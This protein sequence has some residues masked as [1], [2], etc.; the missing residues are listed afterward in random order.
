MNRAFSIVAFVL[1][2]RCFPTEGRAVWH[3]ALLCARQALPGMSAPEPIS[4][5]RTLAG[6]VAATCKVLLGAT[7]CR[8]PSPLE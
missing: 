3:F 8:S 7:P 6:R 5:P 2:G 4:M 1:G